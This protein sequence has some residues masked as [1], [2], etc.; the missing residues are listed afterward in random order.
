MVPLKSFD[1]IICQ[2]LQG[3]Y[4]N[5]SPGHQHTLAAGRFEYPVLGLAS[6]IDCSIQLESLYQLVQSI[7]GID[8]T[9][10]QDA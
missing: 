3:A 7:I 6:S 9:E 10:M 5:Q 1:H 4:S 2:L 8:H